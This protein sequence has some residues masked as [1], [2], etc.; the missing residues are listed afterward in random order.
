MRCITAPEVWGAVTKQRIVYHHALTWTE[1]QPAV[2]MV[3][4]LFV[5]PRLEEILLEFRHQVATQNPMS[6]RF[7]WPTSGNAAPTLQSSNSCR[8]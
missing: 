6:L 7:E 1:Q 2:K 8:L 3:V 4:R 5:W